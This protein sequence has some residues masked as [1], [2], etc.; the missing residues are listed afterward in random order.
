ML[1]RDSSV[2][3]PLRLVNLMNVPTTGIRPS[4]IFNGSAQIIKADGTTQLLSLVFNTNWFEIDSVQSPGIYHI[5]LP[6]SATNVLG[7]IQVTL[8]PAM[9]SFTDTFYSDFV[10]VDMKAM[11]QYLIG[12]Q[13]V[14][15]N[16]HRLTI[17]DEDAIT[18][19]IQYYLQDENSQPSIYNIRNK[20]KVT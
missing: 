7:P 17:Y 12:N 14:D 13:K 6:S 18:P 4:D 5:R 9:S 1:T 15:Q 10:S 19:L 2:R 20:I 16:T 11:M 8:Y 3:I